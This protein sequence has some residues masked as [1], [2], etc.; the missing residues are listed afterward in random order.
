MRDLH[1]RLIVS[2]YGINFLPPL[3]IASY[4]DSTDP[5]IKARFNHEV[6]L[7][8]KLVPDSENSVSF[9]SE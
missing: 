1:K 8:M 4:T 7:F 6:A 5:V 2:L 9:S 3:F